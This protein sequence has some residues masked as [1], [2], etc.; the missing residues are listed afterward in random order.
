MVGAQQHGRYGS[1]DSPALRAFSEAWAWLIAK[2]LVAPDATQSGPDWVVITRRGRAVL[3][4]G[5]PVVRATDRLDVALHPRLEG[6]IRQEFLTGRYELAVF[7]AMREVEIRVRTMIGAPNNLV[8][9]AP[10]REA[11]RRGAPLADRTAEAAS[12]SLRWN[13]S[14]V[15]W[16]PS[17]TPQVIVSLNSMMRRAAEMI[18]FADL[19]MRILDQFV[20]RTTAESRRVQVGE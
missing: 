6:N 19:H 17:R 8:G 1:P 2:G 7:A 16:E 14:L 15:R 18:L 12:K 9:A 10:M 4:A 13:F 3:Q 20:D 5:L 11:F